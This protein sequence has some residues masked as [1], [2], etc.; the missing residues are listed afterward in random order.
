MTHLSIA[1]RSADDARLAATVE[2]FARRIEAMPPG[3]CPVVAQAALLRAG[4]DQTCGKCVPCRDGLPRLAALADKLAACAADEADLACAREL[5]QMIRDT[6]DCAIGYEAAEAF[7]QGLDEFAEEYASHLNERRCAAGIGQSV[8]CETLCPAHVNA[9]GYIALVAQGD[10]AGAVNMVRKDNPFPTACAF[11]CEH[12]CE[13]RCRRTLIDAPL[14]IRGIKR[15]AVDRAPANTVAPPP[16]SVDTAR[17]VAVIGGGPSGL[18]CAYFL[19]LMGHR[20]TVFE[21]RRRL[22]GMMRYGIPAYRFPRARLDEDIRGIMNAGTI[23]VR[24]GDAVDA[25]R[26]REIADTYHAVYVAIGAQK[27]KTLAIEGADAAGVMSA[28]D[29]LGRI[30]DGDV[31]DFSG[32]DV[33]VVG[34]GNVAMD[35]ARTA[36]RAGAKSVSVAYRRRK[37]D[38]TALPTEVEAAIAEG[39]EMR[40]L[41]APAAIEADEQGRCTAL[42]VQPQ[43]IGAVKRGRPAP[44]AADK[45]P[46][47][48]S[49]DIVLVAVGQD[50]DAAPFE[51]CGLSTT[52]G[53]FDADDGLHAQG[54]PRNVFVG[55]DCQTG[56]ATVIRAI[57]AGKVAARNIDEFLGYSHKLACGVEAPAAQP[58]DRT[59]YGRVELAERPACERKRDFEDVECGM[60]R[61]EVL[62]ECGRCLRCDC[63]GIGVTEGGRQQYA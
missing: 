18:T 40:T 17:T 10:Y 52:W 2:R 4:A 13:E 30:G 32:K 25:E 19:A 54:G 43:M 60:S 57:A 61:E 48:L 12:P 37:E 36:V 22:G 45:P 41:C 24:C 29:L 20:V 42:V 55:G 3:I 23:T 8:P 51:E 9:P 58:N 33:V 11:V 46:V 38:M 28:V 21:A 26:F 62:Q 63:F 39:V 27:G 56:P 5:A 59:P 15:Y 31:P 7:L 50:I 1:P 16:R 34:G 6:S 47:R 49:A 14:N 53:R 35:C 44:V